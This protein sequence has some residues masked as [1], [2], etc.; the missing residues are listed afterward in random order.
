MGIFG[1]APEVLHLRGER[2]QEAAVWGVELA[3]MAAMVL[4]NAVLA[5]FEIALASVS[6]A[7]LQVL[8]RDNH[9][10]AHAALRMKQEMERSLAVI[11]L[12]I[13]LVAAIA[14]DTGGMGAEETI[15][16]AL[17]AAGLSHGWS[18]AAAVALV[19]VPLTALTTLFGELV[20]KLFALRN[21]EWV[22]L[23]LAAPVSWLAS[24][25]WPA[26]WLLQ[27]SATAFM[28]WG[29]RH[30]KPRP[31]GAAA[32]EAAELQELRA[33]ASLAVA[34]RLIGAREE[35][36][37]LGAARLSSRPLREILLPAEHISML[38]A[39]APVSDCLVAAHLDMHNRFPVTERAG[40][41]QAIVGYVNFKDIVAHLRVSPH[42]PSL[43]GILRPLLSLPADLPI[44]SA[45]ESLMRQHAHIALVRDPAGQVLG[46]VTLED[47]IEEL[48]G[49][50]QDE[51]DLLPMHATRS[52]N[53]WI[54]GGGISLTRLRGLA[55]LDLAAD[56][57]PRG[58]RSLT[59]W[60]T[61]HLG[62]PVRGGEVVERGGVRLVVRKVRRQRVLKAQITREALAEQ[63]RTLE[64]PDAFRN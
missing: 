42:D 49:D 17:Q 29:E 2:P 16:P 54:L 28:T 11:Q 4:S 63:G 52:G 40:D 45:L 47:I 3:V 21:K 48:V 26:I 33:I 41:P 62:R 55:D 23:K 39:S 12:G 59:G 46:M 60:V 64:S 35:N 31:H 18:A 8:V 14:A 25:V 20:P 58:A 9:A 43:R 56:S 36:I 51:Y 53:S 44:S 6:V 5:A 61:G 19:V 57:P 24:S 34:A 37:I 1:R 22:C 7:R 10:G 38:D 32:S 27:V 50:I 30:W 15:A 13:A